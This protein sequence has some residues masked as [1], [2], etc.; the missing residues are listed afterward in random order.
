MHQLACT[1]MAP[2]SAGPCLAIR[3]CQCSLFL[4]SLSDHTLTIVVGII[5]IVNNAGTAI[6]KCSYHTTLSICPVLKAEEMLQKS[7]SLGPAQIVGS[8]GFVEFDMEKL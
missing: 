5:S 2:D 4:S 3:Q 7:I 8:T 1:A 6:D